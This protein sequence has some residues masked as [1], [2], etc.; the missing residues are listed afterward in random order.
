MR[1]EPRP[2]CNLG[3]REIYLAGAYS[4]AAPDRFPVSEG[5]I[6]VFPRRHLV[7]I[8]DAEEE[9]YAELW[10]LVRRIRERVSRERTADGVTV[11]VNDGLAAGQTITH[12]H[13]HVIPRR[14]GDVQDPRGGVRWVLPKR[15]TYWDV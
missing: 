9:E 5:H 14:I 1:A 4:L 11:G 13:I 8:F 10:R 7:S 6:L 2:F 15:A 3:N 12:A